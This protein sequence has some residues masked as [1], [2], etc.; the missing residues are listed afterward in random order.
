MAAHKL[1]RND[2]CHCGSGRKYKKCCL[3]N[4]EDR[5][6]AWNKSP[7][8][9]DGPEMVRVAMQRL[10]DLIT[11]DGPLHSLRFPQLAFTEVVQQQLQART[12]DAPLHSPATPGGEATHFD[13]LATASVA[14]LW[15]PTWAAEVDRQLQQALGNSAVSTADRMALDTVLVV[16]RRQ[17]ARRQAGLADEAVFR[18]QFDEFM[19]TREILQSLVDKGQ[20]A[21]ASTSDAQIDAMSDL[22]GHLPA[23]VSEAMAA[24][25][26][27]LN[28]AVDWLGSEDAPPVLFEDQAVAIGTVRPLV[29]DAPVDDPGQAFSEW[30]DALFNAQGL[31][32]ELLEQ[33]TQLAEALTDDTGRA[34]LQ[35]LAMTPVD[36]V[37]RLLVGLTA[38]YNQHGALIRTPSDGSVEPPEL[39]E[40]SDVADWCGA[41]ADWLEADGR[42][43]TAARM[44]HY[45]PAYR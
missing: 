42:P 21:L 35:T 12:S 22:L 44:R 26:K 10:P 25:V 20:Q 17:S 38:N 34:H 5:A 8:A 3:R 15:N 27:A 39:A 24:Q 31:A 23:G 13:L 18:A 45:G 37:S 1:G 16:H 40:D 14:A 2:K 19:R 4:D 11:G 43:T 32:A 30:S 28:A 6:T 36:S 29:T 7:L 9:I 41:M 33:F